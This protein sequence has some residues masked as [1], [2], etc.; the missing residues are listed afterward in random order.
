[1]VVC[2]LIPCSNIDWDDSALCA[3]SGKLL[4]DVGWAMVVWGVAAVQLMAG[5]CKGTIM[6]CKPW[7]FMPAFG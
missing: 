6:C 4:C 3:G 2:E 7:N 5:L 1:M